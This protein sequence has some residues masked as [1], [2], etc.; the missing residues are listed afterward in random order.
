MKG[1]QNRPSG[2]LIAGASPRR[3]FNEDYR[4]FLELVAGAIAS[5]ISNAQAYDEERKRA[6]ALAELDRAKTTFFSNVSH[7]F[8]TPLTLML[9]PMEDLLSR[10]EPLPPEDLDLLHIAYRNG[11]RL[12]K[13]VNSLLDFALVQARRRE[14][15]Y[16]ATDLPALTAEIASSFRPAMEKANLRFVVNCPP[17]SELVYVDRDMWE[18]IVL[19]LLSNAFK[20]TLEGTIRDGPGCRAVGRVGGEGHRDGNSGGGSAA[21]LRPFPPRARRSCPN[22]RGSRYR[23]RSCHR[24]GQ[25]AP[26]LRTRGEQVE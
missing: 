1:G 14:A 25:R 3:L 4:A 16:E 18:K 22:V 2:F 12:Q 24:A 26:R 23:A 11:I 21:H 19:N 15:V 7:E 20:F 5:S 8:R 10:G 17:L 6:Q 9:G 13:L